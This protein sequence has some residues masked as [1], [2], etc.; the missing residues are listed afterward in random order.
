MPLPGHQGDESIEPIVP[1]QNVPDTGM[2]GAEFTLTAPDGSETTVITGADGTVTMLFAAEGWYTLKE[3]KAPEWL[4]ESRRG[5]HHRD[6]EVTAE[7]GRRACGRREC[8][9]RKALGTALHTGC[10]CCQL[11]AHK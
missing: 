11:L 8:T 2:A 3:T 6:R 7:L 9:R 1:G 10:F 4:S 5:I